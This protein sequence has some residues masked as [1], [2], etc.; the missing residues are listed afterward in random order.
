MA[1]EV[2]GLPAL[3]FGRLWRKER[4]KGRGE[5][6]SR[7]GKGL[8]PSALPP[9]AS[10]EKLGDEVQGGPCVFRYRSGLLGEIVAVS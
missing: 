4:G 6:T 8:S 9:V 10:T 5:G 3:L 1:N 2:Q 7:T